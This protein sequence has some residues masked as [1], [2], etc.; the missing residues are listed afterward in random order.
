MQFPAGSMRKIA[1]VTTTIGLLVLASEGGAQTPYYAGKT[2]A[3]VRG[4]GAGGSGEF[5]SAR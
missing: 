5:Q 3:I 2:I 4:G 1:L